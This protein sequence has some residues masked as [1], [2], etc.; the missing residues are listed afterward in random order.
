[1]RR[2]R[3]IQIR[4]KHKMTQAEVAKAIGLSS[5]AH[6]SMLESGQKNP[7]LEVAQN[8]AKLFNTTV[9]ELF[10][11]NEV[12]DSDIVTSANTHRPTTS[13]LAG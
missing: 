1:M 7:S 11:P 10:A 8:L 13:E 4:K 9:E 6:I 5:D 2:M 3:L 12:T